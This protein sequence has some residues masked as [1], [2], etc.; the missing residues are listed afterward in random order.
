M[1]RDSKH[2]GNRR[3]GVK[4]WLLESVVA[5]KKPLQSSAKN[6]LGRN[7]PVYEGDVLSVTHQVW[8]LR[9]GY[10]KVS[11]A[12]A[13]NPPAGAPSP[14]TTSP[15]GSGGTTDSFTR[16]GGPLYIYLK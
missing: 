13:V 9:L 15:R 8:K 10:G 7:V 12:G 1:R 6:T 3:K 16:K 5:Q 14:A 11:A 4:Q 2:G